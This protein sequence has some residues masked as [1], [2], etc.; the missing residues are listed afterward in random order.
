[1]RSFFRFMKGNILVLT[2]TQIEWFFAMRMASPYFS[3]YVLALGGSATAIGF[4][5]AFRPLASLFLYP[6]AGYIADNMSRVKV[7]GISRIFSALMY[8]FY[9]FA[10][11]WPALAAGSFFMGIFV[12]QFPAQS[13]I[14]A[15]SLSP[16]RRGVGY[17]T[18]TAV[19]G[20]FSIIA[21]Y[22]GAYIIT[23]YG[24]NPGI[25]YLYTIVMVAGMVCAIIYLKFLK[26]TKKKSDSKIQ[27]Q[28]GLSFIKE[29]YLGVWKTLKWMP[30][31]LRALA[32]I[33]V[34]ILFFTSLAGSFWVVYA[35]DVI[36]L[37]ELEWGLIILLMSALRVGLAIPGGILADKFGKRKILIVALAASTFPIFF[38]VY[39][40]T[41]IQTL[42][43]LLAIAV[44]NA[45]LMPTCSA[46]LADIVPREKRNSVMSVLV[47]GT[48]MI[49]T[50][51][52]GGGGPRMGL[53]L[54]IPVILA[55]IIS[56]YVYSFNLTYPWFFLSS[57]LIL[58]MILTL[59]LVKEPERP[60]L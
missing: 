60:E 36:K 57:S 49:N 33:M 44:S 28:K 43:V 39:C 11:N 34:V 47:R 32:L 10:P 55:S 27:L 19:P 51:G 56:G 31:S 54:T 12:F 16:E 53:L 13:A 45:F 52:G 23:K 40:R 20:A 38:F 35:V 5:N 42:I 1:M 14:T 50:Q 46:L 4:I 15:D 2:I 17:A 48:L 18:L 3:L 41:V 24:V 37:T 8:L 29:A 25:R 59:T 7:I 30:S 58:C 21:P 22:V 6:I 9:I 26:E